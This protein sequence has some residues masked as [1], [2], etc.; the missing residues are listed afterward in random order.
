MKL[1]YSRPIFEQ[2]YSHAPLND[3]SVNDVRHIQRWSHKIIIL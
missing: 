1:E 2:K 3:V